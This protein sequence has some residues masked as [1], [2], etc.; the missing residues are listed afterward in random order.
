MRLTGSWIRP[1]VEQ[2]CTHVAPVRYVCSGMVSGKGG[3]I[4]HTT[5]SRL[6]TA[7]VCHLMTFSSISSNEPLLLQRLTPAEADSD[8]GPRILYPSNSR[9]PPLKPRH[10]ILN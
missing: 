10:F 5:A 7:P 6:K 4:N 2:Q 3:G 9:K 8:P 1:R